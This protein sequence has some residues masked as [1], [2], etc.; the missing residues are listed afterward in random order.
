MKYLTLYIVVDLVFVGCCRYLMEILVSSG[1]HDASQ[2]EVGVH[3][4]KSP[5]NAA[6]TAW[7]RDEEQTITTSTVIQPEIQVHTLSV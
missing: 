3:R 1:S 5:Y 7:G 6:Q 4:S 2:I